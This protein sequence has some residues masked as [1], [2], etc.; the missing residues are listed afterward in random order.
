MMTVFAMSGTFRTRPTSR[1]LICCRP[2]SI[3]LP[4][5]L[6]LLF[7]SCCPT[8]ARLSPYPISLLGSTRTWYSRVGPPKLATS[9]MSGTA[10]K[11]FSTTQSS[12]DFSS[13]TS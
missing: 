6:A 8:W 1:I 5:A 10:L 4:P 9:T 2:A 3:K 11:F 13:I 7:V 12:I